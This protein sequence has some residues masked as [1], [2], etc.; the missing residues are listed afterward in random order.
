MHQSLRLSDAA[1]SKIPLQS[2]RSAIAAANPSACLEERAIFMQNITRIPWT[3]DILVPFLPVLYAILDPT[4][5]PSI[6][7]ALEGPGDV[8]E[9]SHVGLEIF[10]VSNSLR[11]ILTLVRAKRVP[12]GASS[13]IWKNVWPWL[14]FTEMYHE[15]LTADLIADRYVQQVL[16]IAT[17]GT[18]PE[19]ERTMAKDIVDICI[20]LGRAWAQLLQADDRDNK[21]AH[22]ALISLPGCVQS[23]TEHPDWTRSAADGLIVGVGGSAANLASLA[24]LH[25]N[26]FLPNKYSPLDQEHVSLALG[27]LVSFIQSANHEARAPFGLGFADVLLEMGLVTSLTNLSRAVFDGSLPAD[28]SN[29]SYYEYLLAF[30][31]PCPRHQRVV[32]A[33][34]AGFLPT[35]LQAGIA[36]PGCRALLFDNLSSVTTLHSS[37]SQIRVSLSQI[38]DINKKARL[39]KKSSPPFYKSWQG[40][41]AVLEDRFQVLDAYNAEILTVPICCHNHECG[42]TFHKQD[43]KVCSGCTIAYYCSKA[44]QQTDWLAGHRQFCTHLSWRSRVDCHPEHSPMTARDNSFLHTLLY[45]EFRSRQKE[46][47]LGYLR[48]MQNQ[49]DKTPYMLFDFRHGACQI[50]IDDIE[51]LDSALTPVAVEAVV[52]RGERILFNVT[53]GSEYHDIIPRFFPPFVAG[54]EFLAGLRTIAAG[55]P[56]GAGE[57]QLEQYCPAV[58]ML[59]EGALQSDFR[60]DMEQRRLVQ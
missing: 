54:R 47:A 15:L 53:R 49:P 40:F 42:G 16:F 31:R 59:M 26:R 24:L 6:S 29:L 60:D 56:S 51:E 17:L 52:E 50:Q 41:M 25:L 58:L 55:M 32:E 27:G 19:A 43:I 22:T 11:G 48:F 30:L 2:R 33:L 4:R 14:Q 38:K 7:N 37:L 3:V 35:V 34:R 1:R 10:C 12:F 21:A 23:W 5:I 20:F 44:C 45:W 18:N 8:V 46:I 57:E 39:I 9:D 28:V 36:L 13:D